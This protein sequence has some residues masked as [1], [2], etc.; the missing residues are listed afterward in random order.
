VDNTI[1]RDVAGCQQSHATLDAAVADLSDADV[2]QPSLL[3]GWTIGHLLTHIARNAD[4]VVRRLEGAIRDEVVDQYVGGPAGRAEE[5][6]TGAN[7]SAADVI[8]DV[9]RTNAA[10]DEICAGMPDEAWSRLTRGVSGKESPASAVV[11][12]RWREVEV[13]H[14]D[15][16]RGYLPAQWPRELVNAW[17]PELLAGLPGRADPAQLLAWTLGRAP[18][19]TVASWG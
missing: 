7:R 13:H 4:S 16:G 19:P 10:V 3:P 1:T 14:V 17:L 6:D 8:D 2:R 15:L 12:S 5:I 11:F 18:A 9:R